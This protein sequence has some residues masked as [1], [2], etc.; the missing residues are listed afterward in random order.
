[1]KEIDS[2]C[3]EA[4][5]KCSL[6][7]AAPRGRQFFGIEGGVAGSPKNWRPLA[8]SFKE[9]PISGAQSFFY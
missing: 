6:K 7:K 3:H 4:C 8:S 5:E 9:K 1:M 2:S